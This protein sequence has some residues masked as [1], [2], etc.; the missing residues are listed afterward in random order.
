MSHQEEQRPLICYTH[1]HQEINHGI[2]FRE[3]IF[4]LSFFFFPFAPVY[5]CSYWIQ[6][7]FIILLV[8]ADEWLTLQQRTDR[9]REGV[10]AW[11]ERFLTAEWIPSYS[12]FRW[13]P[14]EMR[15]LLGAEVLCVREGLGPCPSATPLYNS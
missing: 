1:S 3:L 10:C 9:W 6:Y 4:I 8:R 12:K 11:A 2:L 13:V 14:C 15:Q 7:P 5:S